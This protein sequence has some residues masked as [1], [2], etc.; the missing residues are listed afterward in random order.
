MSTS[1]TMTTPSAGDGDWNEALRAA[2]AFIAGFRSPGTRKGYRRDLACWLEFCA[3]HDVHP[4]AGVRRTHVAVYLRQLEQQ[5]PA[6]ANSTMRRRIST[7]SSWFTWLEDEEINIGNPAARVRRPRR[8]NRPQPRLDRNEL[9]DLLAE[10]TLNPRT[11]E[12]IDQA[13]DG[14]TI[15][16]LLL[17]QWGNRMQRHNAAAIITRLARRIGIERRVTARAAPLLHHH[18]AAPRRTA[19]RDATRRPPHQSR[20]VGRL[21]REAPEDR[22]DRMRPSGTLA[23]RQCRG[24]APEPCPAGRA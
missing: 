24:P 19:A 3:A 5:V 4:F 9:T 15:G 18:R 23:R 7:L 21:S 2:A 8:H 6:L 13:L 17:N 20:G 22:C 12:A 1:T 11:H 16:P 14:R 10:I